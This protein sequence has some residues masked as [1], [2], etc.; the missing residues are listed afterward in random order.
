MTKKNE[1]VILVS[2]LAMTLA[3]VGGVY[4]WISQATDVP[5]VMNSGSQ[6]QVI[7]K[8]LPKFLMF[9]PVYFATEVVVLGH[10]FVLKLTQ[11]SKLYILSLG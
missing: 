8:P 1:T 5:N 4:F 7:L 6:I 2:S 10:Q 11:L 9:L 3:L